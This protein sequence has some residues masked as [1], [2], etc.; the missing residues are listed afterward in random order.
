M[1]FEEG[2]EK[3][4]ECQLT[5][6]RRSCHDNCNLDRGKFLEK[7]PKII[8]PESA[9]CEAAM[10]RK[11]RI[12][13]MVL[14]AGLLIALIA[15]LSFLLQ[16]RSIFGGPGL[17]ET[18]STPIPDTQENNGLPSQPYPAPSQVIPTRT[19][20]QKPPACQF[21]NP[22]VSDSESVSQQPVFS[23]PKVVYTNSSSIG[24]VRWLPDNERLLITQATSTAQQLIETFDV[25]TSEIQ[26]YAQSHG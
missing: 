11:K 19:I 9:I 8:I 10:N 26:L 1:H 15:G 5:L 16:Q 4:D 2:T 17:T 14:E 13:S 21:N 18:Q 6:P 24:I 3:S 22:K 20:V 25:K 23:E 12:L 7:S